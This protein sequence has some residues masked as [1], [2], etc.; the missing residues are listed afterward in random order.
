MAGRTNELGASNEVTGQMGFRETVL[1]LWWQIIV[2]HKLFIIVNTITKLHPD[3]FFKR[4]HEENQS[5][6][7]I[8]IKLP[9]VIIDKRRDDQNF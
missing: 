5:L 3:E 2:K 7:V 8:D 4:F 1:T 6:K 9:H